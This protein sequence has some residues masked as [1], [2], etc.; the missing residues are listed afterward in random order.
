M[1]PVAGG[2]RIGFDAFEAPSVRVAMAPRDRD[3]WLQVWQE[4]K[5]G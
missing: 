5:H 1:G 2:L 4:S 3:L